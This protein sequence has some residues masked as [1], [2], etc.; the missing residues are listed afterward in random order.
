M[1]KECAIKQTILRALILLAGV[2]IFQ[3]VEASM[4]IVYT[5]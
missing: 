2:A 5:T 4:R 3:Y 1:P